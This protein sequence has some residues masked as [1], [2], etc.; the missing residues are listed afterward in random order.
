MIP[1]LINLSIRH[2]VY[3]EGLKVGR[4]GSLASSLAKLQTEIVGMISTVNYE[5]LGEM[6][7]LELNLLLGQLVRSSRTVFSGWLTNLIQWLR[8]YIEVDADFWKF[9]YTQYVATSEDEPTEEKTAGY[10]LLFGGAATGAAIYSLAKNRPMGANGILMEKFADAYATTASARIMQAVSQG[11]ANSASKDEVIKGIIGTKTLNYRDGLLQQ[12]QRQGDA[13]TNTII[14]HVAGATNEAVA[15]QLFDQYLWVSVLDSAT[16]QICR[17]RNGNVYYYGAGPM[18]PAHVGCRSSTIAFDGTGP[19]TMPTFTVWRN[20]QSEEFI[21]D[22][23]DAE[24]GA[25]YEGASSINLEEFAGKRR[26]ITA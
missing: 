14:Q 17:S 12:L 6:R 5:D 11:Y 25:S 4:Q 15:K 10:A 19:I 9:A 26:L 22:A 3:L 13:V 7:K 8:D 18:P 21:N 23:F 24:P 20:G 2:Q 1:P 16:T